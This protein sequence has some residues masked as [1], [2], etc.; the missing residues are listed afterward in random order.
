M[1]AL[2]ITISLPSNR[3]NEGLKKRHPEKTIYEN[4]DQAGIFLNAVL[5]R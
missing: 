2:K 5:Q 3:L 4:S 1:N